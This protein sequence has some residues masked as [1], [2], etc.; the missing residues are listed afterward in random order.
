[1]LST[2]KGST[3]NK[4]MD[5]VQKEESAESHLLHCATEGD[6][7]MTTTEEAIIL[8]PCHEMR[9][10]IWSLVLNRN[11]KPLTL[12]V[13]DCSS[14][15]WRCSQEQC[16]SC[17]RAASL[18]LLCI[19]TQLPAVPLYSYYLLIITHYLLL[20]LSISVYCLVRGLLG[21]LITAFKIN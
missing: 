12:R 4:H 6:R 10:Y 15:R 17:Q 19:T 18:L 8:M 3:T 9:S 1:M 7:R 14:C 16:T 11:L 20:L 2:S 5:L 13:T 21:M